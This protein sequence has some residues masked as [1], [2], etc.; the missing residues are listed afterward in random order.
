M[1]E[2]PSISSVRE[3]LIGD[4]VVSPEQVLWEGRSSLVEA[5]RKRLEGAKEARRSAHRARNCREG[6]RNRP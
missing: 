6:S 2:R 4:G 3:E 1:Q 5:L